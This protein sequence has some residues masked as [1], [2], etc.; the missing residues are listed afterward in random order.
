MW[1]WGRE[2]ERVPRDGSSLR[3]RGRDFGTGLGRRR[4]RGARER[5]GRPGAGGGG[6]WKGGGG[7][8][9]I[10]GVEGRSKIWRA[11]LGLPRDHQEVNW[12][13]S[14]SRVSYPGVGKAFRTRSGREML[15]TRFT[16]KERRDNF[17]C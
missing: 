3:A 11:E 4:G 8:L 1:R 15:L 16:C 9:G 17:R 6:V 14:K 5:G 12:K 13:T 7:G 2:G 10:G